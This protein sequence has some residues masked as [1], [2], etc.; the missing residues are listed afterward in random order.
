MKTLLITTCS[1]FLFLSV[2]VY[3]QTDRTVLIH[4]IL[5]ASG[6]KEEAR[7]VALEVR[8]HFAPVLKEMAAQPAEVFR[9]QADK[10]FAGDSLYTL[11]EQYWFDKADDVSRLQT[12]RDWLVSPLAVR[13]RQLERE[14]S[15]PEAG[16]KMAE[17]IEQMQKDTALQ[18]RSAMLSVLGNTAIQSTVHFLTD[19][20][21]QVFLLFN[22]P[23]QNEQKM[24]EQEIR[25]IVDNMR[26]AMLEYYGKSMV[27]FYAYAYRSVPDE[28][29]QQ[30]V[31]F[32]TN[33]DE[34]KWFAAFSDKAYF[35]SCQATSQKFIIQLADTY[36]SMIEKAATAKSEAQ[37]ADSTEEGTELEKMKKDLQQKSNGGQIIG[38]VEATV[39][40]VKWYGYLNAEDNHNGTITILALNNDLDPMEQA[41]ITFSFKGTG[42]YRIE[43]Q[44][45]GIF[46]FKADRTVLSE[47]RSRG[48]AADKV[49]ITSYDKLTN[50]IEG[51]I[52]F[53]AY[54]KDGDVTFT[55]MPFA[56]RI[57]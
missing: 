52:S 1:F 17:Y 57:R 44:F 50:I 51:K 13:M 54:G 42:T 12:V 55:S 56:V 45:A 18:R 2:S 14:A 15:G 22:T 7:K 3:S 30:Y 31:H 41:E 32:Y 29:L 40:S 16:K 48:A 35:E 8:E 47:F 53:T 6:M 25:G 39:N 43:K 38:M 11:I 9:T 46:R 10:T 28:E 19:L 4:D 20:T 24:T 23:S 49:I 21:E 27:E 26:K 34:G 33:T 5:A 36:A 37:P